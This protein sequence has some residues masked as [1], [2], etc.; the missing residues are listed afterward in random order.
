MATSVEQP[1]SASPSLASGLAG[2]GLDGVAARQEYDVALLRGYL[3]L[4]LPVVMSASDRTLTNTMFN[5]A[6][7]WRETLQSFASDPSVAV[8]YV[9]KV[10]AE[11]AQ[12]MTEE[13]DAMFSYFL[14]T[15]PTYTPLYVSSIALIKRVPTL[16]SNRSLPPQLHLLSLFGPASSSS[17]SMSVKAGDGE[18]TDVATSV[19]ESPYE[20]LHSVVHNVMA[21]WFDAYVLSKEG[22]ERALTSVKSKDSDLKMG[23][24]V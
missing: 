8:L 23:E 16:D 6:G 24:S 9:N 20:A 5:R 19:R 3:E 13:D 12:E 4:L 22:K 21:P 18:G 17:T 10:R 1:F 15:Q 7:H 14:T 2:D 11:E